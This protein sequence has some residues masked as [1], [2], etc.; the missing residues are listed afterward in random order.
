M[1]WLELMGL[2]LGLGYGAFGVGVGAW[3]WVWGLEGPGRD[4]HGVPPVVEG[5]GQVGAAQLDEAAEQL[6]RLE[7]E[8]RRHAAR[9]E[10][11]QREQ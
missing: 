4:H 10:Q 6:L 9:R 7:A 3:A 2:G 5:V 1:T 11:P 8:G